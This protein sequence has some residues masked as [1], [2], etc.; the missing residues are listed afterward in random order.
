MTLIKR[1]ILLFF[2]LTANQ[3]LSQVPESDA[4]FIEKI[5]REKKP[6]GSIVYTNHIGETDAQRILIKLKS[7]YFQSSDTKVNPVT[8]TKQERKIL[9]NQIKTLTKPYWNANLFKESNVIEEENVMNY[10]RSVYNHYSET[11]SDPNN[12]QIDKSNLLKESPEPY[13][14]EFTPPLYLKDKTVCM[15][16][17]K[18][19][20]GS[21][22]GGSEMRFYKKVSNNWEQLAVVSLD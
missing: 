9:E 2:C 20:C 11:L 19:L 21:N 12:S 5:L 10:F 17:I 6:D 13:V 3:L 18:T 1:L 8:I 4:A 15:I 14:F 22:C 7:E 16:F